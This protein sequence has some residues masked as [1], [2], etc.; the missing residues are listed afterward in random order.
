M[1]RM[2]PL[3]WTT[4]WAVVTLS[5]AN[6][7]PTLRGGRA[8][9]NA[10]NPN[11]YYYSN[12]YDRLGTSQCSYLTFNSPYGGQLAV[13]NCIS[14]SG[15]LY[16]TQTTTTTSG[17]ITVEG[18]FY[19]PDINSIPLELVPGKKCFT[20][21]NGKPEF[22]QFCKPTLGAPYAIQS[23]T[24]TNNQCENLLSPAV[25]TYQ[26]LITNLAK[27]ATQQPQ[28]NC[29]KHSTSTSTGNNYHVVGA[30]GNFPLST[31]RHVKLLSV[32]FDIKK[33]AASVGQGIKLNITFQSDGITPSQC[34]AFTTNGNQQQC[35]LCIPPIPSDDIFIDLNNQGCIDLYSLMT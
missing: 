4:L 8:L 10:F 16:S 26:R 25:I 32:D 1:I 22:C 14:N 27:A 17:L 3:S 20:L 11:N 29:T 30:M 21:I 19:S 6:E 33:P 5:Q 24:Y 18:L 28:T 34:N 31:T 9:T 15:P 7:T 2:H 23:S 35:Q 12:F 13:M